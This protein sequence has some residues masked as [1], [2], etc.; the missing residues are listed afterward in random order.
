MTLRS[1]RHATSTPPQNV[2][3]ILRR[4]SRENFMTNSDMVREIRVHNHTCK[5]EHM[6]T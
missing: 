1:M 5:F 3:D 6:L 4:S 2:A